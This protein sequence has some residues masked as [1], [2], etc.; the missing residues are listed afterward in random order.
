MPL[1]SIS[2]LGESSVAEA[3][4]S[5]YGTAHTFRAKIVYFND[6]ISKGIGRKRLQS[7]QE[8]AGLTPTLRNSNA[9]RIPTTGSGSSRLKARI[10]IRSQYGSKHGSEQKLQLSTSTQPTSVGLRLIACCQGTYFFF[11]SF[12]SFFFFD[13]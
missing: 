1:S 3:F 2:E 12:F 13:K 5:R 10:A 8:R 9:S 7:I 4:I 11:F 6:L